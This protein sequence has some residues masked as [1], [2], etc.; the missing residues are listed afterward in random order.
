MI[1]INLV[2][3]PKILNAKLQ[4][5]VSELTKTIAQELNLKNSLEIDLEFVTIEKITKLNLELR[6]KN[7][8]TDVISVEYGFEP[9][10]NFPQIIGEIYISYEI[11]AKQ[12]VKFNHSYEREICFLVVHGILHLLGYDHQT[13]AEENKMFELQ[14]RILKLNEISR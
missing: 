7:E 1:E 8:P 11:A 13:E 5:M 6:N 4:A 2:D 9:E 10:A 3:T 12:A 14:E